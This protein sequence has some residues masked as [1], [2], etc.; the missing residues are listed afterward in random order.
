MTLSEIL[1]YICILSGAVASAA[2]KKLTV[3]GAVLG[4]TIA[5][6]IFRASG[7]AGLCMMAAFFVMGIITT[8]LKKNFKKSLAGNE[9]GPRN[10]NQVFANGGL[11]AIVCAGSWVF[12]SVAYMLPLLIAA[13][14]SSAA[15][16][17][18]SSETGNVYGTKFYNIL[19]G[20][21]AA[22]GV[23]GAVSV[24]GTLAGI[25]ASVVI[26]VV[27][28]LF[29]NDFGYTPYIILAGTAGNLS[30]SV[31]GAALENRGYLG[32]NAVN[33]LN[34]LVAALVMALLV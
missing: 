11:A 13:I 18:V 12:S 10:V 21:S 1:V 4:A 24:E 27:Y 17:T 26:A 9:P 31:F 22:R 3:A 20:R 33:F 28:G 14:F 32:N 6:I 30:D 2:T 16:D 34:T 23:N 29:F 5:V 8:S 25:A 15:A 7:I 19:N